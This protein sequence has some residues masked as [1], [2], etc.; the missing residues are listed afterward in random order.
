MAGH[1]AVTRNDE[2]RLMFAGGAIAGAIAGVTIALLTAAAHLIRGESPWVGLK[3]AAYPFLGERVLRPSLDAGALALGVFD[4]LAVSAIWG[5]LFALLAFGLSRWATVAF[6]AA[7]G[8]MALFAMMFL[9]VPLAGAT[10]L[11]EAMAV[12]PSVLTHVTF[13]LALGLAFLPF[14]R[15]QV[16]GGHQRWHHGLPL[17]GPS[18]SA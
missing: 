8:L 14:Q 1:D 17:T 15:H 4:H 18:S 9:V 13:G 11:E 16:D 10:R 2:R 12:G 5:V 7:W 6:G 3:I